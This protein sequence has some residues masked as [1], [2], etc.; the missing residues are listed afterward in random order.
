[1]KSLKTQLFETLLANGFNAKFQP[2]ADYMLEDDSIVVNNIDIQMGNGYVCVWNHSSNGTSKML[3][4]TLFRKKNLEAV[5]NHII[6][7][8]NSSK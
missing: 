2:S 6:N 8:I 5:T 1:M 3:M 4:E 7:L